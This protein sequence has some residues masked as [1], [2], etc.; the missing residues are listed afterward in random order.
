MKDIYRETGTVF[1]RSQL[2]PPVRAAL[3]DHERQ[4]QGTLER[5]KR[6]GGRYTQGL[7]GYKQTRLPGGVVVKTWINP[8]GLTPTL[9]ARVYYPPY[10]QEEEGLECEVVHGLVKILSDIN[11][12][13]VDG[14]TFNPREFINGNNVYGPWQASPQIAKGFIGADSPC[15]PN[16]HWAK[17]VLHNKGTMY[18]GLM[19]ELVQF[20]GGL[21]S[22]IPYNFQWCETHGIF[23]NAVDASWWVVEI[24]RADGVRTWRLPKSRDFK[25][26]E[27]VEF[28]SSITIPYFPQTPDAKAEPIT[29]ISAAGLNGIFAGEPYYTEM[30]WAFSYTGSEAQNIAITLDGD[31][32]RATR[33]KISIESDPTTG[34][35]TGASIEQEESKILWGVRSGC[36]KYPYITD[37]GFSLLSYD[38]YY[39]VP[40]EPTEA[41]DAPIWVFYKPGSE[42]PIVVRQTTY[43]ETSS[44]TL[45]AETWPPTGYAMNTD[46]EFPVPFDSAFSGMHWIDNAYTETE[47]QTH[48][49]EIEGIS[50]PVTVARVYSQS[51][52]NHVYLSWRQDAGMNMH[53]SSAGK[54]YSKHYVCEYYVAAGGSAASISA[55]HTEGF[56]VPFFERESF[57][58][59]Y[60][61]KDV[62]ETAYSRSYY[63]GGPAGIKILDTISFSGD[64]SGLFQ[65]KY[66]T[67]D[68]SFRT[69]DLGTVTDW[70]GDGADS[71]YVVTGYPTHVWDSGCDEPN[72]YQT[73]DGFT[74]SGQQLQ[75]RSIQWTG[76]IWPDTEVTA[77]QKVYLYNPVKQVFE[78]TFESDEWPD[79]ATA[80]TEYYPAIITGALIS[81]AYFDVF[82]GDGLA[83]P[84]INQLDRDDQYESGTIIGHYS[85]VLDPGLTLSWVGVP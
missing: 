7:A 3:A 34:N 79:S 41:H 32:K 76:T 36:P 39:G 33:W 70:G 63:F 48:H 9:M 65:I 80:Y 42:D 16:L 56:F 50:P 12:G 10:L 15:N 19:R 45:P 75:G 60:E 8:F 35:P 6:E 22:P 73:L 43:G 11:P 81:C 68:G 55:T 29:L 44:T 24:S 61:K 26:E 77:E 84:F 69:E 31:Y 85:L 74:D 37:Q 1:K 27:I 59:Y 13:G 46:G 78:T 5:V 40:D 57:G 67:C 49:F 62:L 17:S 47:T 64:P 51:G 14:L 25:D 66:P 72:R 18:T 83:T 30:A 2:S 52:K 20:I 4:L 71:T 58:I 38:T 53:R 23:V 54:V 21:C 28:G 82:T